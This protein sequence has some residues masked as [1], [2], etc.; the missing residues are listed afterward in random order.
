MRLLLIEDGT[1]YE[2]FARL[3]LSPACGIY[4]A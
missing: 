1:E 3:F 4:A 2:E